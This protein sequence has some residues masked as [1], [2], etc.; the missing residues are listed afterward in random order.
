MIAWSIASI[1]MGVIC[2]LYGKT[3]NSDI[4]YIIFGFITIIIGLVLL[5]IYEIRV[6]Q[7]ISDLKKKVKQLEAKNSHDM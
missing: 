6:D 3:V 4:A 5:V 1:I 2:I 7:T